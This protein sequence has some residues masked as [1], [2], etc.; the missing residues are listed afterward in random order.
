MSLKRI[1][2]FWNSI[3][4]IQYYYYYYYPKFFLNVG[5]RCTCLGG[6]KFEMAQGFESKGLSELSDFS[7]T[8]FA[9]NCLNV[10]GFFR[11]TSNVMWVEQIF[12]PPV[13]WRRRVGRPKPH[14]KFKCRYFYFDFLPLSPSFHQFK[15]LTYRA[16]TSNRRDPLLLYARAAQTL[17]TALIYG[18]LFYR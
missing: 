10:F 9:S 14:Y 17:I 1:L 8:S 3:A 5:S 6:M 4:I 18:S 12:R 7:C 13:F 11:N 16:L 15:V 2:I